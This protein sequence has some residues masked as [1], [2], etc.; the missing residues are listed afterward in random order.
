[1]TPVDDALVEGDETVVM[2]LQS[3][4]TYTLGSPYSATMA[5]FDNDDMTVSIA[6]SQNASETDPT[7]AGKGKFAVTRSRT[8][9]TLTVNYSAPTGTAAVTTD[10]TGPS[11]GGGTLSFGSGVATVYL[12]VTP[13]DDASIE[14]TE[15]VI[16]DDASLE[17][18][19]R[20]VA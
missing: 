17:C 5:L 11:S 6:M 12:D 13:V 3:S 19:D 8:S 20:V 14:P 4:F 18:C 9:G 1:M 2:T 7:G 16:V 15:T 10:Y